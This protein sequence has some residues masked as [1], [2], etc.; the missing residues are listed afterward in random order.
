MGKKWW[1][2][3]NQEGKIFVSLAVILSTLLFVVGVS[4]IAWAAVQQENGIYGWY[5]AGSKWVKVG[6]TSTGGINTNVTGDLTV[7]DNIATPTT[8][9]R[10]G[11]YLMGY[12]GTNWDM[13]RTATAGSGI[14][15][16]GIL[17]TQPYFSN[18]GGTEW[19]RWVGTAFSADLTI[20]TSAPYLSAVMRTT[21]DTSVYPLKDVVIGDNL[22]TGLPAT[23]LYGFD[24]TNWDR[25]GSGTAYG[26]AVTNN[27]VLGVQNYLNYSGS[28][29]NVYAPSSAGA[30][31]N[32]A[33]A[34]LPAT[35]LYGFDGTYW[36]RLTTNTS[37]SL[38]VSVLPHPDILMNNI[39]TDASTAVK[40]SAG[41]LLKVIVGVAGVGAPTTAILYN[42][43]DCASL[44]AA[45]ATID[46]TAAGVW[47]FSV[48]FSAG[49][50]IVTS[51]GTTD[52][53]ITVVYK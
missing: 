17:I 14:G 39:T 28:T 37:G 25:I 30:G 51:N 18:S 27:R 2:R 22:T 26:V 32:L 15:A 6:T 12:D 46:T 49:L 41:A 47:P 36:D 33:A 52:A 40:A 29:S 38:N 34:Y 24:G 44:P 16:T 23:G 5:S 19:S 43:A 50:C 45:F 3:K 48:P 13:L 4:W 20:D 31:D 8:A 42:D 35:A 53:N 7:A 10:S 21:G 11:S 9:L 1:E